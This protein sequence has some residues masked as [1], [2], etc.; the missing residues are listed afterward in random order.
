MD[1]MA[2]KIRVQE[3]EIQGLKEELA[4]MKQFMENM[5]Y[6]MMQSNGVNMP[7]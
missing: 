7:K 4:C 5:Y 6:S 2:E 3:E 1:F